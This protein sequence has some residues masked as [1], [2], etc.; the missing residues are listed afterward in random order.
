[1]SEPTSVASHAGMRNTASITSSDTTGMRATRQVS[2]RLPSG[3]ST[4]VNMMAPYGGG[5][6]WPVTSARRRGLVFLTR[7]IGLRS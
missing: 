7:P 4:C 2:V 5:A 6:E 3:S 1:M